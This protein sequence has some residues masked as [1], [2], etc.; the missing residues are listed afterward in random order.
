MLIVEA[1]LFG[2]W[3]ESNTNALTKVDVVFFA[4]TVSLAVRQQHL[5]A[6]F[7]LLLGFLVRLQRLDIRL[8]CPAASY[9]FLG[10]CFSLTL[11]VNVTVGKTVP[12]PGRLEAKNITDFE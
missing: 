1:L 2:F 7:Q 12:D 3:T 5:L 10:D 9:N 6:V 4:V 8:P 11:V